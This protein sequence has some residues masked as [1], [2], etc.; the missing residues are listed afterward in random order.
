MSH[1]A[2]LLFFKALAEPTLFFKPLLRIT[3]TQVIFGF[4]R[5][6]LRG[7]NAVEKPEDPVQSL[8]QG[9]EDATTQTLFLILS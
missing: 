6:L 9:T 5:Y 8:L 2:T 1:R 3:V 4:N 7:A